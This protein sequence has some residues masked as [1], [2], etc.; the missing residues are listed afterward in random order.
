[1]ARSSAELV[2]V[3]TDGVAS[4]QV[5][6]KGRD[7]RTLNQS[8]IPHRKQIPNNK[9]LTGAQKVRGERSERDISGNPEGLLAVAHLLLAAYT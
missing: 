4:S 3:E 5:A 1:M 6:E 8:H 7:R 2:S 9:A